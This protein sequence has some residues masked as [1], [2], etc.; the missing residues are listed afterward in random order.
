MQVLSP[1]VSVARTIRIIAVV[2]D[3]ESRLL[4][5]ITDDLG[6]YKISRIHPNKIKFRRS[7]RLKYPG[8]NEP[9]QTQGAGSMNPVTHES[10][11]RQETVWIHNLYF[12]AKPT[13]TKGTVARCARIIPNIEN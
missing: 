8:T 9:S 13:E 4:L 1:L 10:D 11:R 7:D 12:V 2:V 6:A 5:Q 3:N